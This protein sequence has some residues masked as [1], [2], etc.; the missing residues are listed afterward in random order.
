MWFSIHLHRMLPVLLTRDEGAGASL[1]YRGCMVAHG[2]Q[3]AFYSSL[4]YCLLQSI[5]EGCRQAQNKAAA[6]DQCAAGPKIGVVLPAA[7]WWQ[8]PRHGSKEASA[9]WGRGHAPAHAPPAITAH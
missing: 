2:S 8:P 4:V 6:A 7:F 5:C 3:L 9:G 1:R